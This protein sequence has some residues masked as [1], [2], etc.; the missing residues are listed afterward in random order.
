MKANIRKKIRWIYLIIIN[1]TLSYT[2]LIPLASP[3]FKMLMPK[4]SSKGKGKHQKRNLLEK[5][6]KLDKDQK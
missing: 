3:M 1:L 6:Y 5:V 2:N 4:C